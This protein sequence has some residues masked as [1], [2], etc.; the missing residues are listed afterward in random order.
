MSGSSCEFCSCALGFGR[1]SGRR[2]AGQSKA[3]VTWSRAPSPSSPSLSVPLSRLQQRQRCQRCCWR[4]HG[5]SPT[6]VGATQTQRGLGCTCL[7]HTNTRP[8]PRLKFSYSQ[9]R[10]PQFVSPP[11]N[12]PRQQ[13]MRYNTYTGV[14]NSRPL[15]THAASTSPR[16]PP[17]SG[18]CPPPSAHRVSPAACETATPPRPH[19]QR[20]NPSFRPHIV[21]VHIPYMPRQHITTTTPQDGAVFVPRSRPHGQNSSRSQIPHSG[22]GGRF[23]TAALAQASFLI[24]YCIRVCT[25]GLAIEPECSTGHRACLHL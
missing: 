10:L 20:T 25:C 21:W 6:R 3:S 22:R 7:P 1:G 8:R 11:T 13:T 14:H 9:R 17:G 2:Q 19:Q 5:H 23:R 16:R 15:A 24:Y 18:L 4:R 12:P